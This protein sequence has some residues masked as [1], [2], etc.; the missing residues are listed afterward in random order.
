[1]DRAA[2]PPYSTSD[3]PQDVRDTKMEQAPAETPER[4]AFYARID[5]DNLAPL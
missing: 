3:D 1:M 2:G 4:K 5:K